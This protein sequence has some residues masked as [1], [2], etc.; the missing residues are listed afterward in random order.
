LPP[1]QKSKQ[2]IA[3]PPPPT[4]AGAGPRCGPRVALGPRPRD[5]RLSH[6]GFRAPPRSLSDSLSLSESRSLTLS[7]SLSLP[8]PLPLSFSLSLSLS[9]CISLG[10]AILLSLSPLAQTPG[11]RH[12]I[13]SLLEPEKVTETSLFQS[14]FQSFSGEYGNVVSMCYTSSQPAPTFSRSQ[15]TILRW[16][17]RN[18]FY[19]PAAA[20]RHVIS[21]HCLVGW[22]PAARATTAAWAPA[23][24]SHTTGADLSYLLHALMGGDWNR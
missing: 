21:W 14:K 8:L 6:A 9:L 13:L 11:R 24:G 4:T 23:K 10:V 19:Q 12:N 15:C 17:A 5:S 1:A 22:W 18:G 3:Q 16:H 2:L 7:L 20:Q